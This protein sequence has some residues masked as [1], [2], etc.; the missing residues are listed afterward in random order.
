Q[1]YYKRLG[2]VSVY[3]PESDVPTE[4]RSERFRAFVETASSHLARGQNLVLAPEGTSY[5]TEDSPGP[6]KA[7][8]FRLAGALDPEPW[9]V[10]IAMAHFD[11]RLAH[12]KLVAIVHAPFR[13]S[14]RVKNLDDPD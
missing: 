6:F 3:T 9:I 1:T 11:R 5:S 12:T 13:I 8:A 2:H 14:D 10:P 7:G 4:S